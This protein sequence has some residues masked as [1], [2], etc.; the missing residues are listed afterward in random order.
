MGIGGGGLV[1]F[2]YLFTL[3]ANVC[4]PLCTNFGV[5]TAVLDFAAVSGPDLN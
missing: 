5:I 3:P 1:F 2:F 4:W